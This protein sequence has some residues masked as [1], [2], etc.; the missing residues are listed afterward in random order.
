MGTTNVVVDILSQ[1]ALIM[2][3]LA[4]LSVSKRPLAKLIQTLES[5][6]KKL[7]VLERGGY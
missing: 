3:S 5:K 6:F 7:G 1:K 2:G 4:C